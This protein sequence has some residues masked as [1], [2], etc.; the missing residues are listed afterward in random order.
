[1]AVQVQVGRAQ[2]PARALT[3]DLA[4]T[5]ADFSEGFALDALGRASD[6]AFGAAAVALFG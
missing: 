1:V 3:L 5:P 4:I 6:L 2:A